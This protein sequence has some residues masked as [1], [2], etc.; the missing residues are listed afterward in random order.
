MK[1]ILQETVPIFNST[2]TLLQSHKGKMKNQCLAQANMNLSN[3]IKIKIREKLKIVS[4][5]FFYFLCS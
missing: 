4:L 2:N 5:F 3:K 1:R